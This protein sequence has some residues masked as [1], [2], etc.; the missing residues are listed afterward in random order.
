MKSTKLLALT[1]ALVLAFS[2]FA[3]AQDDTAT[4]DDTTADDATDDATD[5]SDDDAAG[6]FAATMAFTSP[7]SLEAE[8]EYEFEFTVTNTTNVGANVHEWIEM[9][10]LYMPSEEYAIDTDSLAAPDDLHGGS[11][12]V[13][14]LPLDDATATPIGI[15]WQFTTNSTSAAYGDIREGETLEFA[16]RAKSDASATDG[17][18]YKIYSDSGADVQG[19]ACITTDCGETTDDT[20]S[21]DTDDDAADDDDD[22]DDDG[23]CCG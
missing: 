20:A 10:D 18:N 3:F 15:R 7:V 9:L 21:D 11:W 17:F 6:A 13:R 12:S 22:D 16:F 2:A 19:K 4:T 14:T 23:G 1:F 8:I 5:D